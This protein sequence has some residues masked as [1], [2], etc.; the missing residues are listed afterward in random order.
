MRFKVD[1]NDRNHS[2]NS[3]NDKNDDQDSLI[4]IEKVGS[5][6]GLSLPKTLTLTLLGVCADFHFKRRRRH[7]VSRL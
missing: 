5:M 2:T 7:D 1:L 3:R 6:C 4:K